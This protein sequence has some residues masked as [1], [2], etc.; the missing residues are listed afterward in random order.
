MA[1]VGL[2]TAAIGFG[3]SVAGEYFDNDTLKTAGNIVTGT[4][5][6]LTALSTVCVGGVGLGLITTVTK[7]AAAL[8]GAQIVCVDSWSIA[9]GIVMW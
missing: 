8:M 2:A 3:V 1:A 6:V 7:E 4:G 5:I 9:T